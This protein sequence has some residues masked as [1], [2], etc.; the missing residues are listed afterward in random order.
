M[1]A[2]RVA[3]HSFDFL[4]N[5]TILNA[6]GE[7]CRTRWTDIQHVDLS[8]TNKPDYAHHANLTAQECQEI[9]VEKARRDMVYTTANSEGAGVTRRGPAPEP[10]T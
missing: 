9:M 6:N 5:C 1:P 8:Y 4:G 2:E 7:R 10:E 3:G